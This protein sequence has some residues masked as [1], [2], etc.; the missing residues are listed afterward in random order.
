MSG[1]LFSV[2]VNSIKSGYE[3]S[4]V[5]TAFIVKDI[6][7]LLKSATIK[8]WIVQPK[9]T[10]RAAGRREVQQHRYSNLYGGEESTQRLS[11][12]KADQF[13]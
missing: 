1:L 4:S 6:M 10:K 11:L 12:R 8:F 7:R 9:G 5:F 3:R 13:G 2:R